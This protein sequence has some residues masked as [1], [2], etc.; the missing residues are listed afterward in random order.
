MVYIVG[1][2]VLWA[3]GLL[4]PWFYY[5]PDSALAAVIITAVVQMIDYSI[6][7][8]LWIVNSEF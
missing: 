8:R 7:K 3:L 6:I 4:T 1:A 2:V 5:I